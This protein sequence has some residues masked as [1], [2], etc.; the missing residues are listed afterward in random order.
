MAGYERVPIDLGQAAELEGPLGQ[1]TRHPTLVSVTS[2][3][4]RSEE[5]FEHAYQGVLRDGD[6]NN[7]PAREV[8]FATAFDELARSYELMHQSRTA[9]GQAARRPSEVL[10]FLVNDQWAITRDS[11]GQRLLE[12]LHPHLAPNTMTIPRS[13]TAQSPARPADYDATLWDEALF[14]AQY[15]P[16]IERPPGT[17]L[18]WR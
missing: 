13:T 3:E 14:Y 12:G 5:S 10:V 15:F 9:R 11:V 18:P 17:P 1:G 7:P 2:V 16:S 6:R 4:W 8:D